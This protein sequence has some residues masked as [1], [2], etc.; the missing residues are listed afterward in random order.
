[1]HFVFQLATQAKKNISGLILYKACL[2]H[3]GVKKWCKAICAEHFLRNLSFPKHERFL[4]SNFTPRS[5]YT[6]VRVNACHSN[7][8]TCGHCTK[9]YYEQKINQNYI[10]DC[11][12]LSLLSYTETFVYSQI[13]L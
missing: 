13:T 3:K 6:F 12:C 2:T 7:S 5:A 8:A 4:K 1:M 10:V 11:D 9:T